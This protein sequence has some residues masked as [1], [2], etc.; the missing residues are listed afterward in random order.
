MSCCWQGEN[1]IAAHV[2][3]GGNTLITA[4]WVS[5]IVILS[6]GR[7][8]M[9]TQFILQPPWPGHMRE[10]VQVGAF[11]QPSPLGQAKHTLKLS[12]TASVSISLKHFC[13]IKVTL[14][15]LPPREELPV[16]ATPAFCWTKSILSSALGRN[17]QGQ[18]KLLVVRSGNS[19]L[20]IKGCKT[21][22]WASFHPGSSR[23]MM[24]AN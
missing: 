4:N 3:E 22:A 23:G 12:L 17:T 18:Q 14:G 11:H 16:P 9:E 15:G 20:G 24:P 5:S 8:L 21:T 6:L 13:H 2:G 7:D 1:L 19:I 10:S